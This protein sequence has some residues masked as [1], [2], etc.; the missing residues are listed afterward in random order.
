VFSALRRIIRFLQHD[1]WREELRRLSGGKK[2]GLAS[3]RVFSHLLVS[4]SQNLAGIRA[5]G[6]TLIT[7]LALVPLL[8]LVFAIADG[9]GL[10][11]DLQAAMASY[12]EDLPP[13]LQD[14]VGQIQILVAS[15][16][17]TAL[18]VLGTVILVWTALVL[19]TRIEQAFNYV[20]RTRRSRPWIRR[21][22]DFIAVI[23][24]VPVLV[25]GALFVKSMVVSATWVQRLREDYAWV[26][27]IYETG[28]SFAPHPMMWIA[29]TA[30]YKMVPSARVQW[31]SAAIGGVVAGSL[32]I[33]VYGLY[34]DFQVGVAQANAIYATL[35]ALPLLLI[36][37][38]ISWT[39]I[40]AGAEVSYAV[41]N[42]ESLRGTEHMPPASHAIKVRLGWHLLNRASDA[43]RNGRAGCDLARFAMDMDVPREW[44]DG[45]YDALYAGGLL[46]CVQGDQDIAM[47]ARPPEQILFS[48]VVDA[49]DRQ[50]VA[51]FLERVRLPEEGEKQLLAAEQAGADRL[52]ERSF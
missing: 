26:E 5:A 23:V 22:S 7:L 28:I 38:Q 45:V 4:F 42:L 12:A 19:F 35:A 11:D 16:R 29:F 1:L 21:V 43:F 27:F 39:I 13:A 31:R 17:F 20:W 9:F 15:V 37:L 44:V 48:Q 10:S 8:A 25:L 18:G 51:G 41:Q 2:L 3:L 47:P 24:L 14:A 6:L 50:D 52:A 33:A 49:V 40:L 36:Y 30:L 32:W 46:V 34:L